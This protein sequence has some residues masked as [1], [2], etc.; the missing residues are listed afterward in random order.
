[1]KTTELRTRAFTLI[2]LLVVIAIIAILAAM[3]LPVL[4]R[5][6]PK[7]QT[8]VCASNLKQLFYCW[9]MYADDNNDLL[10]PNNS[11][12]GTIIVL[13]ASW[14]L[15]DPT[16]ANVKDGM[17]FEYNK[18]LGIYH[19]PADRSTLAED[20]SGKL[21]RTPW[22]YFD[23]AP[24]AKGGKGSPRARSYNLSQSVN[25]FPD[26]D[27]II[28]ASIP[29]FSKLTSIKDP[30][31]S[32]CLLFI[33]EQEYTMIDSQ[34]GMPTAFFPGG[35]PFHWWDS[36]ADR[37]NL[38]A[39]LSYADGHVAAKKWKVPKN[40]GAFADPL[41]PPIPPNDPEMED[42]NFMVDRIKQTK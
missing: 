14:C 26:Y 12:A 16:E 24:G 35:T 30:G 42:W 37:H 10:V 39:N 31:P 36:P 17:L 28:L 27:P 4:S 6:K 41:K 15:A 2:E 11:V 22:N 32:N 13:G 29:M 19:C 9:K 34:F 25:G 38:A 8:I 5:S 3:L 40:Y 1:M 20:A 33:D 7:A 21:P 18:S 23:G